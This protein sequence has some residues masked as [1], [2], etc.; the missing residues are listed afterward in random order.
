MRRCTLV[1]SVV[2]IAATAL[3][4][5]SA[6]STAPKAPGRTMEASSTPTPVPT[7]TPT[8]VVLSHEEAGM[9]Y[10]DLIC[11]VNASGIE[12]NEAFAA[13]ED[14]FLAGGTPD[15][16]DVKASAAKRMD[17]SRK[18]LELLDDT[19][20][21]WPTEVRES[22]THV[23]SNFMGELNGLNAMANAS[24]YE[25]AYYAEPYQATPEEKSAG[26]EIRYELGLSADTVASCQDHLGKLTARYEELQTR[27]TAGTNR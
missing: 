23:R 10:L 17:L 18:L 8:E 4:G 1:L 5:C 9:L 6:E 13:K 25:Q 21:V 24:T 14:E 15:P 27:R 11:D 3:T 12:V 26:Q 20:Y 7:P 19:Y 22:L 16:V 2:A